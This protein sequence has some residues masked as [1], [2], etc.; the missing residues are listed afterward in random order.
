[1]HWLPEQIADFAR[2]WAEGRTTSEIAKV[3]GIS[4][5][6]VI[7]KAHRLHLVARPNPVKRNT[8][9]KTVLRVI[10]GRSHDPSRK[11]VQGGARPKPTPSANSN[12]P[13]API[14]PDRRYSDA[15][16]STEA[17]KWPIGHPGD[18]DFRFCTDRALVSKPYCAEHCAAAFVRLKP[19]SSGTDVA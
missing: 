8:P 7:G 14:E 6:A 11:I 17:C 13:T 2:L 18:P 19:K 9:P 12:G 4:K 15:E 10:A 5:N 3:M 16:V 1:M